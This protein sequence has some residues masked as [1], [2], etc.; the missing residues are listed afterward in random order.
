MWASTPGAWLRVIM[1]NAW[2]NTVRTRRSHAAA[3]ADTAALAPAGGDQGLVNLQAS[4]T[5]LLR[6][7]TRIPPSARD[8]VVRCLLEGEPREV[9]STRRRLTRGAIEASIYRTRK[10]FREAGLGS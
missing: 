6:V 9:V 1:R 4:R 7:W 8:I 5:Q 3:T 10:L 2:F